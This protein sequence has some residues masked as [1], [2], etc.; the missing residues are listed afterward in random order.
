[1]P[2]C[3]IIVCCDLALC[4][5]YTA[6]VYLVRTSTYKHVLDFFYFLSSNIDD[7]VMFLGDT[8]SNIEHTVKLGLDSEFELESS[9]LTFK[10]G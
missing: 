7:P 1:M 6:V 10:F 9:I 3:G 4:L 2:G 8:K 5:L